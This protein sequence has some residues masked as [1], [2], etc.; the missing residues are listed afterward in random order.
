MADLKQRTGLNIQTVQIENIDFLRDTALLKVYY[1]EEEPK[2]IL[3]PTDVSHQ[4]D[5]KIKAGQFSIK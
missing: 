2:P 1:L 4:A 3:R 5:E